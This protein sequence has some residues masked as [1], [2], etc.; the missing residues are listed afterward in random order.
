MVN[1]IIVNTTLKVAATAISELKLKCLP[2]LSLKVTNL[3][4]KIKAHTHNERILYNQQLPL[5]ADLER[6]KENESVPIF[7]SL[8]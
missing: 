2:Q 3:K 6:N 4:L 7:V 1:I 5:L 8:C